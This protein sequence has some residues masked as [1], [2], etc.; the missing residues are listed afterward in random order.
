MGLTL[1]SRRWSIVCAFAVCVSQ[2]VM[3]QPGDQPPIQPGP[4]RIPDYPPGALR[5]NPAPIQL[6]GGGGVTDTGT[7]T[8][9][10]PL[11]VPAGPNGMQPALSLVHGGSYGS[12]GVGFSL[13]GLSSIS[14]CQKT[15]ASDG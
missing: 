2:T 10:L 12:L 9:T 13:A 3:A 7:A 5:R 8:Y 14:P 4:P 1:A 15:L 11:R 6:P